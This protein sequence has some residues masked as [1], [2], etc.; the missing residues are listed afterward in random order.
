MGE[1]TKCMVQ[2]KWIGEIETDRKLILER[3]DYGIQ[4]TFFS[5][6]SDMPND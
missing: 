2:C 6:H 1:S 3:F 5:K 4:E